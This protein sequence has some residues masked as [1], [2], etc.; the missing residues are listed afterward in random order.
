MSL[1]IARAVLGEIA[2]YDIRVRLTG[3]GIQLRSSSRPP[4]HVVA[5]MGSNLAEI[6]AVLLRANAEA[7]KRNAWADAGASELTPAQLRG[8]R[9]S[10]GHRNAIQALG[11]SSAQYSPDRVGHQAPSSCKTNCKTRARWLLN[12][13]NKIKQLFDQRGGEGGIRT[14]DRL[15]PMPHFE[16]GAFNRSA[17]SPNP[18]RGAR[19]R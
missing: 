18:R 17:T 5:E 12:F 16:C 1:S 9:W 6:V 2:S 11:H 3:D 4:D 14:P 8:G 15:A 13:Y 19:A 10:D 7:R